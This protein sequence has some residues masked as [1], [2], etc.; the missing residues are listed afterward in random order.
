MVEYHVG[1]FASLLISNL[2]TRI[3]ADLPSNWL[4]YKTKKV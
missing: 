4:P 2:L 1:I 3:S